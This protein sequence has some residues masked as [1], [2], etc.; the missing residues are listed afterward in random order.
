MHRAILSAALIL[1]LAAR[2][3]AGQVDALRF[4]AAKVPV[5]R[6]YQYL[7]SNRD[8]SHAG[9]VTVYVAKPDRL[10]SLKWDDEVGW[11]S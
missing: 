9:R 8:G 6:V 11:A 10:E 4:D 7:K 2:P 5:G 1:A 3:A